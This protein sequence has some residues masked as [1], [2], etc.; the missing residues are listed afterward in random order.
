MAIGR[1]NTGGGAALGFEIIPGTTKPTNPKENTI[2]AN[3]TYTMGSWA[4]S[5]T[6]PHRVSRTN[7]LIVYP[8]AFSTNSK[9]GVTV[10]VDSSSGNKGKV[11]VNGTNTYSG[12]SL[13]FRLSESGIEKGE[14]I[15]QPGTYCLSGNCS[16]SSSTTHRLLVGYSYD[17]WKTTVTVNELENGGVFTIDKVAKARVSIQVSKGASANNAVYSPML[18]KGSTPVAY[19]VGNATGQIWV[20]T[21]EVSSFSMNALRKNDIDIRPVSVYEYTTNNGWAERAAQIYQYGAWSD[22]KTS[23]YLYNNGKSTGYS[24]E[25]DETMKENSYGWNAASDEGRI[26]VNDT[27]ITIKT[28]S[29]RGYDYTNIFV[30]N[31]SG[32]FVTVNLSKYTKIR[33][34]GTLTGATKNTACVFRAMTEMGDYSTDNNVLSQAFY[35][36]TIDAT[37]DISAVNSGCYLGFTFYE[38]IITFVLN[39]L[40]LE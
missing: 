10:T 8:Y 15:L 20:K 23:F 11:T 24:W 2:W 12:G 18:V 39:E 16:S 40:W 4:I 22:I 3:S 28:S 31:S 17:N 7:N 30:A 9:N 21:G 25:C 26:T 14:M 32:S 35:T 1:T 36:G 29:S 13:A 27:N 5:P 33:I 19:T 34:K 6:E 37:I 38:E